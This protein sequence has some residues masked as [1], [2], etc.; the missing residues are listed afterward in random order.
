MKNTHTKAVVL[1]LLISSCAFGDFLQGFFVNPGFKVGYQFG[2]RPGFVI[3]F[4]TSVTYAYSQMYVYT[5]VVGGIELNINQMQLNKY[6]EA[7]FGLGPLGMA[8]GGEWNIDYFGSWR[9]FAGA[10]GFVS[11]K[12]LFNSRIHEIAVIGKKPY[13]LWYEADHGTYLFGK[14][15]GP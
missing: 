8:F 10:M 5:G 14:R 13:Y 15:T 7:E 9:I 12:H 4:E 6:W 11:Y 3:G 2:S 1:I